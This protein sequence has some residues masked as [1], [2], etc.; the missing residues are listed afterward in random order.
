MGGKKNNSKIPLIIKKY[1]GELSCT[2][3]IYRIAVIYLNF[4]RNV[5]KDNEQEGFF[6][7]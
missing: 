2:E 1:R 5:Q 3:A 4:K 7:V 6:N